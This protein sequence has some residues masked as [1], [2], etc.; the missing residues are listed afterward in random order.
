M[1]D[2]SLEVI[3]MLGSPERVAVLARRS[4]RRGT[5]QFAGYFIQLVRITDSIVA[6][7]LD[8]KWGQ[9]HVAEFTAIPWTPTS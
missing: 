8:Y 5:A 2:F 3:D 1:A 7:V 4:G 6:E 9:R